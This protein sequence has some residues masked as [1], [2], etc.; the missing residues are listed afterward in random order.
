MLCPTD[1][2]LFVLPTRLAKHLC[3]QCGALTY[4][5][6]LRFPYNLYTLRW[7]GVGTLSH[8]SYKELTSVKFILL[9]YLK[10]EKKSIH[11]T[12]VVRLVILQHFLTLLFKV[13][14]TQIAFLQGG[15][16][17]RHENFEFSAIQ[18]KFNRCLKKFNY[19]QWCCK[20]IPLFQIRWV[21]KL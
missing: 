1:V 16:T 18:C 10:S 6:E 12:H 9:C 20:I 5:Q 7:L 14:V 13:H 3:T 11:D 17:W 15:R 19:K 4:Y 21:S 8:V 2:T